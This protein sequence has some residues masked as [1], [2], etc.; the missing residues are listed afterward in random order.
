VFCVARLSPPRLVEH[1]A[2]P[3]R[4]CPSGFPASRPSFEASAQRVGRFASLPQQVQPFV[5]GLG[6]LLWRLLT[7]CSTGR[8]VSKR[9]VPCCPFRHKARSPRVRSAT[10]LPHTRRIYVRVFLDDYRA[11]S[12]LALSPKRVRLLCDSCSSGREFAF[13]FLPASPHEATVAVRLTVP[14]IRVRRG[15]APPSHPPSTTL[16]RTMLSHHVPYLAHQEKPGE[17]ILTGLQH[18]G[19]YPLVQGVQDRATSPDVPHCGRRIP[20]R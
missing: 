5:G 8:A 16:G 12:F 15:L 3:D 19:S 13:S 7:P 6:R 2:S 1:P 14:A 4:F 11:S 20:L 17:E 9:S 18:L 10:F